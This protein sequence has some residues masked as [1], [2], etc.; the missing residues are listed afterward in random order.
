M[1]EFLILMIPFVGTSA[2]AAMVF[3]MREKMNSRLEKLLLG[4]ASGVMIAASIWS[5]LDPA[6][7]MT[8]Q[9]GGRPWLPVAVGFLLGIGF[10]LA[11]DCAVP[12]LHP[13]GRDPEGVKSGFDKTTMLML[14]VSLHNLPEG[15]AVGVALAGAI[16]EDT[17]MTMAGALVLTAG[18]AIQNFP[19]GAIISMPLRN[20]GISRPRAFW[21]GVASGI[22]E[23]VGA[24]ATILLAEQVVRILPYL[25]AFAAGAM[26]YVVSDE[27]IPEARDEG[28]TNLGTIGVALGFVLMMVLDVALGA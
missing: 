2:G 6:I 8:R 10:L 22:V 13:A 27:L 9:R 12:H 20:S 1:T 17:G 24:A 26:I 4:F 11:L 23:P 16:L 25:L 19:E 7:E 28:H 3:F 15:M 18:I 14:A 21:Y 5:L